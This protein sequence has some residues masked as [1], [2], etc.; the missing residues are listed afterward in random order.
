MVLC[1]TEPYDAGDTAVVPVERVW[2]PSPELPL[3]ALPPGLNAERLTW[4][5]ICARYP[6]QWVVLVAIEATDPMLSGVRSSIVAGHGGNE[7]SFD[8][9]EPHRAYFRSI[10]H[11]HTRPRSPANT[12]AAHSATS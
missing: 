2:D 6:N 8:R 12:L 7:E 11:L 1:A 4:A 9:A 3:A 10:A 5:E